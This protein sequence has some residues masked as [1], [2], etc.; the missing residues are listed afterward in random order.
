MSHD[1][2]KSRFFTMQLVRLAGALLAMAGLSVL[3][4]KLPLPQSIGAILFVAGI[5]HLFVVPI[6][7]A[8]RWKSPP[9]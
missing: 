8:K 5:T 3:A 4:G 6:I 1:P 7:L 2:A 9:Q